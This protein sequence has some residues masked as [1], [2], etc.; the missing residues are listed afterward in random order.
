MDKFKQIFKKECVCVIAIVL[1]IITSFFSVPKIEY[2]DFKV[3]ILLFNLM[4]IV[5]CFKDLKA[6]DSIATRFLD[7]CRTSRKVTICLVLI[8]FVSSMFITNDVALITFV[9]LTIVIGKKAKINVMKVV[10]YQTLAANLGSSLTPM[11][12][13]QN[14]YLYSKYNLS[15]GE[16]LSITCILF[17]LSIIFILALILKDKNK[18][19]DFKLSEIK[20]KSKGYSLFFVVVFV[21]VVL[22]VIGAIDYRISFVITLISVF[23][24]NKKMFFKVDYFLLLTFIGFYIFI[25]NISSLEVVSNFMKDI[26]ST[27]TSTYV[28]GIVTSQ[29]ISN[30]PA[31]ILLSSFTDSFK[32]LILAVN[33]GGMGTIIASMASLISFILYV[34]EYQGETKQYFKVFTVY[35]LI[36]LVLFSIIIYLI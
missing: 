19:L 1:A 13:P 21:L 32:E 14:L 8:S 24:Y 28:L 10:I 2:I 33:I 6:L 27:D 16:F 3:L 31:A 23:L 35:N 36:G 18:S 4:I 12:N 20:I 22:S 11:G 5:E 7:K 29:V 25:G 34:K 30:V 9:P 15:I 17:I 26:L